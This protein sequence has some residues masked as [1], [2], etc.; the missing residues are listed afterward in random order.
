[1]ESEAWAAVEVRQQL[2]LAH[3]GCY[4]ID[5]NSCLG[6]SCIRIR[7]IGVSCGGQGRWLSVWS[8]QGGSSRA[9][10]RRIRMSEM[11]MYAW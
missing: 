5:E 7:S 4:L 9:R 3:D 10:C 8:E 6:N 11:V 1:M 2:K